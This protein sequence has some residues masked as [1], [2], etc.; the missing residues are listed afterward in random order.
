[1]PR[2][3][4]E[5]V[6]VITGAS[7]GMGRATAL[8]FGREG[9][10]VV[11][12]ARN[13]L[14]LEEVAQ[15][16]KAA[17]SQA[18]V[19][20]TDV[21]DQAAVADLAQ[22][23]ISLFGRIDTWINV[24]S[25]ALY[26]SIEDSTIEEFERIIQV[27]LLGVIYGCKAVLPYMR[28]QGQGTIINFGSVVSHMAIPLL[29][30]YSASKQGVKGFTDALRLEMEHEKTG[31]QVTLVMPAGINTPF[32]NHARSKLGVKPQPMPP[33]YQPEVVAKAVVQAAIHPKRD[34]YGGGAS[35]IFSVLERLS[36]SI[37]DRLLMTG[38][39]IIRSQK[40]NQPDDG[41]DNLFEPVLEQGRIHGDYDS[42]TKPSL[43]TPILASRPGAFL[44]PGLVAG[45]LAVVGL[46]RRTG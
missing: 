27:N 32:F 18:V 41:I 1:M 5:Q 45:A 36:P 43:L 17:G 30:A 22:K 33:V 6:I 38:N 46:R 11:L 35:W 24:A 13:V 4:N 37:V 21:S 39:M 14:A 3:L 9:A 7:S 23:T 40:S 15:E 26:A 12:A 10:I 44:L 29:A 16:I 8:E 28:Q 25:V 2:P 42:M 34:I 20:P 31:I 19:I